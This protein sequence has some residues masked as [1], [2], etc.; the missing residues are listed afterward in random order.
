MGTTLL[1]QPGAHYAAFRA[2][3]EACDASIQRQAGWSLHELLAADEATS[4]LEHTEYA[5]PAIVALEI[6]LARLWESWGIVPSVVIGHSVGEIAAA[7]IA[8]V[9]DLDEA[10]R[11][12]LHRGRLMEQ[13]T[14]TG[15]MAAAY[16]TEADARRDIAPFGDRL[17]LAAV[18]GPQSVVI[19]GDRAAVDTVVAAWTAR[20]VGCRALPVDYAFH[21][22]QVEPFG[23]ELVRVLGTVAARP[24]TVPMISTVT[25]RVVTGTDLDATYWGRN[26]RCPVLFAAAVDEALRDE[27]TTFLEIGPHPVLVASVQECM[28]SAEV[29]DGVAL[30]SLRRRQDARGTLLTS[31]GALFVRGARVRW[32]AV[33]PGPIPVLP[34]PAYPYQRQRFW[35]T[36]PS[37]A[38]VQ[39]G[40]HSGPHTA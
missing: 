22:A 19:S 33:Y 18:N 27:A 3:I 34:L 6:A 38:A 39:S 1:R 25:G 30:P 17:S 14:G 13:A 32:N 35:V 5:Q 15:C 31:L 8:G 23:D 11:I 16:L 36:R 9:L 7:H 24:T 10:M 12:V 4:Q 40:P 2:A 21:S 29:R 37:A 26:V 28:A 20:G